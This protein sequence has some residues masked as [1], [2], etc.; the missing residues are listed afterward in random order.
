MNIVFV[1]PDGMGL[2][3]VTTWSIEMCNRLSSSNRPAVLI[4]HATWN[5]RMD[6]DVSPSVQ[7]VDCTDLTRPSLQLTDQDLDHY[8]SRYRSV[9]PGV[10]IP[11]WSFGAYAACAAMAKDRPDA[12][13]VIG[14]AHADGPDYYDWIAYYEPIIHFFVAVSEEI[15]S[16]LARLIPHRERDI[17]IRPY[18]VAVPGAPNRRNSDPREPLRLIYAGRLAQVQKRIFDLVALTRALLEEGVNFRLQIVGDGVDEEALRRKLRQLDRG[19]RERVVFE[20]RQPPRAMPDI[21]G[22]GE[23][24]I[25]V[26]EYEGTSI[27]M[28]ESMAHGCVPVMTRVSGTASVIDPGVNG[29]LTPVGDVAEMARIIRRLDEGRDS[30]ADIGANAHATIAAGFSYDEY[31]GWFLELVDRA[32]SQPARAW[33]EQRPVLPPHLRKTTF[34]GIQGAIRGDPHAIETTLARLTSKP[35]FRWIASLRRA[36]RRLARSTRD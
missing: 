13:R 15:A 6:V 35:G 1:L 22:G 23:I 28:L 2:G 14:F 17:V 32:W 5:S 10:I 12:Q 29:F 36:A 9:M 30:L 16:A 26:S 34:D 19:A 24:A 4:E 31:L 21:W 27:T 18:A 33:P 7:I 11:N 20:G 25:L 8:E 3:G